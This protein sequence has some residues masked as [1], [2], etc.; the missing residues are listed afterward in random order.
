MIALLL[1]GILAFLTSQPARPMT[2]AGDI[3]PIIQSRCGGCHRPGGDAPF[4]LETIDEV[5][6]RASMIVTVTKSRYMPP[7]KPVP[8]FG[9][10]HGSRRMTV[11]EIAAIELL[12]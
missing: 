3:A 5:R 1:G 2:F 4:S 9:T 11:A 12:S 7:W 6:R 10:F 8:G